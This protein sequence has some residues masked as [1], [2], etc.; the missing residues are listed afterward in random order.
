MKDATRAVTAGRNPGAH[1]GAVN[2]P[3]YHCST[4]L[5]PTFDALKA[6]RQITSGDGVTYGVH[7]TPGTYAC[8][9]AIRALEGG[10]R[11]RLCNSGLQAVTMPLLACLSAGDHLLMVDTA[12]GPTRT[13]CDGMLRRLG[14]E[15]TYYDPL[16]GGGIRE[17]IRPNTRV[18]FLESPG[19][20]TF[21]V[22]DVPAIAEEAHKAGAIVMMD[23]TWASP[24]YF[25]PFEHGV[26]VSI[27]AITKYIGGHSDL[28]M[29]AVTSNETVYPKVRQGWQELGLCGSPDDVF[30]AMR[31]LRSLH[32][33]MPRHW[34]AGLKVGHWL[35]E[36]PEIAEVMHPAMEH[37][38]GH[39]LWKRDFL[40]AA[41]LFAFTLHEEF[42]TEAHLAALLDNLE[43][44]GMGF[45]WGGYESL[46]IPIYP[47]RLRTATPWPKQGR[48]KGQS[49][50]IHIGLEDTGDLIDDLA[51]GLDR[52]RRV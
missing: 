39:A 41:S 34:E 13:F 21:E 46:L 20:W 30:L 1:S 3:V 17:L 4:I 48:P 24:L 27:Q 45:S 38:P 40:G 16:V 14:V 12:Y 32:V 35:M 26:D 31:G 18:V 10:F 49:L 19:S 15:T 8:E 9:E 50:R 23:N 36:R 22:Q 5:F 11:T 51:A 29:G 42:S 44:F 47:S 43:H 25:K 7:G 37:D 52:M 6:S 28:V 2:P 33:R